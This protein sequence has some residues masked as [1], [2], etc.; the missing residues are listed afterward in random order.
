MTKLRSE[1]IIT[2]ETAALDRRR[3]SKVIP[4]LCAAVKRIRNFFGDSQEAF[5]RRAGV[6]L[7][8]ICKFET[9]RAEPRDPRVLLN[10]AE[11]AGQHRKY[12][13]EHGDDEIIFSDDPVRILGENEQLFRAAYAAYER[14]QQINRRV[15]ELEAVALSAFRSVREWRLACASRLAVLYFP[16]QV[17]AMEQAAGA[18]IAIIDEVLSQA[19]ENQID[20]ARFEREVFR[21]AER[22]ALSEYARSAGRAR[23]A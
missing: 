10:I 23:P 19:D 16:E 22:R 9:G 11:V 13:L 12:L 4:P 21:L 14:T 5:G 2:R 17:A 15:G 1:R 6:A 7:M 20:Y 18:A 8:T 3:A